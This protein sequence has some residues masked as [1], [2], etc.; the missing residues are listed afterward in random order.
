MEWNG[1]MSTHLRKLIPVALL[2]F[3]LVLAACDGVVTDSDDDAADDVDT[4]EAPAATPEEP[5]ADDSATPDDAVTDAADDV[6]T[7][8]AAATP[9]AATTPED[10]DAV[11]E[12]MDVQEILDR[13]AERAEEIDTARF[14]LDGTGYLE[15]EDIGEVSLQNAEGALQRPDRVEVTL[16]VDVANMEVPL[17]II[18]IDGDVYFTDVLTGS[19]HQVPEEFRFNPRIMFDSDEGIPALIRNMD[20]VELTG[21]DEVGG[22]D[23]HRIRGTVEREV[24]VTGTSGMFQPDDD[25]D[26]EI[27]IDK[28]TYDVLW[29]RAEDPTAETDSVWDMRIF[30]HN[31]DVDIEDPRNGDD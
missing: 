30:D 15:V 20:N 29:L 24:I 14:E 12:D 27:W 22:R 11:D 18:A 9:D 16:D 3:A 6:A 17:T 7:P 1:H 25:V 23:A 28:E 26:F 19:W 13:A 21:S 2:T 10:D 31:E 8:E 5:A 4:T